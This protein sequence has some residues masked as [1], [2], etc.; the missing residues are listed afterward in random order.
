FQGRAEITTTDGTVPPAL[1][2][3]RLDFD[4]DGRLQTA[5]LPTCAPS[6][7]DAATPEQARQ[8][9]AGAL[10]GRGNVEAIVALPG[11]ERV[12]VASPLSLFNGTRQNG[13]AT[14][15][16]HAQTTFPSLETYVVVIPVERRSGGFSYRATFDI[17]EIAAGY[18]ALTH[19]DA[20]IGR[21]YRSGGRERSYISARCSDGILQ[22]NGYASFADG[23]IISGTLFK[24]CQARR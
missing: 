2:R 14:V 10:V 6:A 15:L 7:I 5:G 12:V 23:T 24:G 16:A 1:R 11:Q 19:V 3:I 20:K 13:H 9:C 4:R 8:T 17:P 18:G 21:R 22:T